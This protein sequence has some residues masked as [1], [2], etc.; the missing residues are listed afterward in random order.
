VCNVSN[1]RFTV[2]TQ[3]NTKK[4][5]NASDTKEEGSKDTKC[6]PSFDA[7]SRTASRE[8]WIQCIE[9]KLCAREQ[10]TVGSPTFISQITRTMDRNTL[11][12]NE[13]C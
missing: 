12:K 13:C 5:K 1:E 10:Y 7:Y 2:E 4:S 9:C 6:L 3:K 11:F 8:M